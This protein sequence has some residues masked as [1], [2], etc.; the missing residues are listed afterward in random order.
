[1]SY[2]NKMR[3]AI[4]RAACRHLFVQHELLG[5]PRA[6][7]VGSRVSAV[8]PR[9]ATALLAQLHHV[10]RIGSHFG[11]WLLI[12]SVDALLSAV[13]S[14]AVDRPRARWFM[15]QPSTVPLTAS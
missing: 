14:Q 8:N 15:I 12:A 3:Y 11:R 13:E 2:P 10:A 6:Q 5:N 7:D 9:A 1:M 4:E